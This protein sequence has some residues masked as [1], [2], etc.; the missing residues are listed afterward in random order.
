MTDIYTKFPNKKLFQSKRLK[1]IGMLVPFVE[2]S[3]F[4]KRIYKFSSFQLLEFLES[5]DFFHLALG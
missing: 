5:G 1:Q 2:P 4:C 3:S